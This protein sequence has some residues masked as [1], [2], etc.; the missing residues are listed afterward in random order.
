MQFSLNI[1][2]LIIFLSESLSTLNITL[3]TDLGHFFFLFFGLV[4]VF[5]VV[6]MY[7]TRPAAAS[8]MKLLPG[9]QIGGTARQGCLQL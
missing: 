1:Y 2:T 4:V 6:L 8:E 5:F 3:S 7:F 9:K